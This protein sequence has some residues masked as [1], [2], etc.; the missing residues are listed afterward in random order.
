MAYSTANSPVNGRINGLTVNGRARFRAVNSRRPQARPLVE[1]LGQNDGDS[2]LQ[3]LWSP[4]ARIA[5]G[6]AMA[7]HGYRRTRSTGWAFL[8]AISGTLSPPI[9]GAISI[10][11][12]FGKRKGS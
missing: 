2:P 6:V 1:P 10:A 5:G 9:M 11:Q 7:Y 8:W 4:T 12:G 3:V